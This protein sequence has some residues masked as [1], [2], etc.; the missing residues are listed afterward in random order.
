[1]NA[2]TKVR[3][4]E[5][6]R[7]SLVTANTERCAKYVRGLVITVVSKFLP[8]T[9][10]NDQ[11]MIWKCVLTVSVMLWYPAPE[12]PS[13]TLK[14]TLKTASSS[15]SRVSRESKEPTPLVPT[16]SRPAGSGVAS[17]PTL[18][19]QTPTRRRLPR[20]GLLYY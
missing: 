13:T 12:H 10:T 16:N 9:L 8:T 2:K 20:G 14:P 1:M 7:R 11:D 17:S 4:V 18:W 5:I 15:M 6:S 19:P 3:D